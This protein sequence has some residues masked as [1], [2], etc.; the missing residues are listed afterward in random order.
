[1]SASTRTAHRLSRLLAML[2]WVMAHPGCSAEEVCSRFGYDKEELVA[3]LNL[4]MVCGVPGYGPGD[5]M[6]AELAGDEVVVDAAEYFARSPRLTPAETLALLAAGMA[7]ISGG[8]ASVALRSAVDKLAAVIAPG[9]E[10]TLSV[11]LT[12]E[13]ESVAT[14]RKASRSNLVVSLD[15]FSPSRGEITR[16]SVEPWSVF[17]TLGN[18]YLMGYC[19]LAEDRRVFRID[20][21]KQFAVTDDSFTPP[22]DLPEP[23]VQYAPAE[24]HVRATILLNAEAR[25]VAEYYPVE[26]VDDSPAGLTVVFSS[27]DQGVAARLLLRL[28]KG[29]RLIEGQEVRDALAEL[30]ARILARYNN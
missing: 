7:L 30:K 11:E 8:H 22:V 16:R 5:L 27:A 18:W 19:R 14:L 23:E 21:I 15:Y 9:S 26:I 3:D 13:P 28:G 29:A 20:R 25:W 1:M 6:W 4:I 2:P 10:D 24:D 12:K 17:S